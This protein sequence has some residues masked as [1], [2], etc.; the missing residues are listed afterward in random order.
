MRLEALKREGGG[1]E[2][3]ICMVLLFTGTWLVYA[4]RQGTTWQVHGKGES[5]LQQLYLASLILFMVKVV[6]QRFPE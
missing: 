1:G 3:V 5:S 2:G 4:T 6:V